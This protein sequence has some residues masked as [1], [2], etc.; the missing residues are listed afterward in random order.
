MSDG[1]D[2][3]RKRVDDRAAA[4]DATSTGAEAASP[5]ADSFLETLVSQ[6][7]SLA[8]S[9]VV[10]T[11]VLEL[12][13]ESRD[14]TSTLEAAAGEDTIGASFS[15]D[16]TI[17]A[18]DFDPQESLS[19]AARLAATQP[20]A[21]SAIGPRLNLRTAQSSLDRYLDLGPLG[22]GGMGAVRRVRD[23]LLNRVMAMKIL[24][25]SLLADEGHVLRFI[26]EAQ[27]VSQLQHPN[28]L[29]VYDLGVLEGGE[30]FFTMAEI[31]GKS[32]AHH[33]KGVHD[34]SDADG[35]H[36][37][38][39]DWN[40]HRL[41]S[42]VN[43]AC[44]A[45]AYAHEHGVVYRD[46]KPE[47]VMI[48]SLGEV[49]VVDWGLAKIIGAPEHEDTAVVTTRSQTN[50]HA[51]MVG[52]VYGTPAYLAPELA[53]AEARQPTVMSDVY[54]LG[55][56]LYEVLRG[57]RPFESKDVRA[58]LVKI[59]TGQATPFQTQETLEPSDGP[60]TQTK[61]I[62]YVSKNG[63]PIPSVLVEVC[64]RA[65]SL[66][67]EDRYQ[68]A[69]QMVDL[70]GGWLDGSRR[71]EMAMELVGSAVSYADHIE[72]AQG[73]AKDLR[74]Q[75]EQ[76]EQGLETWEPEANKLELW[77][78]QD[79]AADLEM[80]ASLMRV[81]QIQSYRGALTYKDD[82]GESHAALA[83]YYMQAHQEAEAAGDL[84][85]AQRNEVILREHTE[86][87]PA[88]HGL[89]HELIRYLGGYGKLT[90][91]T[92]P[93]VAAL[94]IAPMVR[95]NRRRVSGEFTPLGS[96]PLRDWQLDMGS[97]VVKLTAPGYH[98]V[99]YPV[100]NGRMETRTGQNPE[101]EHVPVELLPDGTLGPEDC[102]VPAGWCWL[103]GD[104]STPNSLP[105]MRVW[106]DGF[107]I[108]RFPVTHE[109]YRR[110]LN[111]LVDS[112]L[113]DEA[114]LHVPR[115]QSSSDDELGAMAYERD[116]AGV[117][118]LPNDPNGLTCLP[119]QPVTMIQWRSARAYAHWLAR[120]TGL[121]WRLPMEFEWEKAARGVD[122]RYY[123]WGNL[124]D[125]SWSCMKDSHQG[126]VSMQI[127]D[128]YPID[129][130]VYG[131]RGTAGNTR[132]WCLD[133]FRDSGPPLLNDRLLM[134][135]DED[136]ADPGFKATRGGSYG[137]SASRARSAD[138]DWW[139]PDRSYVG[140]G[141]RLAWGLIDR[142][143]K[144]DPSSMSE[145]S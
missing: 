113:E 11:L 33:I 38:Q 74:D 48:G 95:H 119:R 102:Y 77:A 24:H 135:T 115:E 19:K 73:Q 17:A 43:D 16:A 81:K 39:G 118:Q 110:F 83:R 53:C 141:F 54:A 26:Q 143:A 14:R 25:R 9:S 133:R 144:E 140:R 125:P 86:S 88:G 101:G 109:E 100:Y 63:A 139:F 35:W 130:S 111:A 60:E 21:S 131:V 50:M 8:S 59:V 18:A 61:P 45:A 41:V 87:M 142:S 132:D 96:T 13:R 32:L 116:A 134:P 75:A 66:K 2:H 138:R 28:I 99:V 117:F 64:Q 97:F 62:A 65:M 108:R 124:H 68:S 57:C 20:S 29:P 90:I 7:E 127:V 56:I 89:R 22:A 114:L 136:I 1:P 52:T 105:R 3:V 93:C 23:E 71:R 27:V 55:V 104:K 47:N 107:V 80:K 67:P 72:T 98:P 15:D 40:L 106:L 79:Q 92:W 137:N 94:S 51:T 122:G 145:S 69:G 49:L 34:A 126:T 91:T 76:I 82:L 58:L 44:K 103:G 46:L 84:A 129:E 6:D 37:Q 36:A 31:Q 4:K 10:S 121:P 123:P 120:R 112:G 5:T 78:L 12:L 70:I 30:I 128:T 85:E 42:V